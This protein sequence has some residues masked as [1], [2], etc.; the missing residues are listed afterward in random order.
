VGR[1]DADPP[2]RAKVLAEEGLPPVLLGILEARNEL[3]WTAVEDLA[4]SL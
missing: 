2:E 1:S 3:G 4:D